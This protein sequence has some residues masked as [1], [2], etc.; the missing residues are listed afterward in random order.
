MFIAL[1]LLTQSI[2]LMTSLTVPEPA[3]SSDRSIHVNNFFAV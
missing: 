2:F 3:E 1:A